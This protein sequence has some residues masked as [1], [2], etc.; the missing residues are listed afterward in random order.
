MSKAICIFQVGA[1]I[2]GFA[3]GVAIEK[4]GRRLT[5]LLLVIPFVLGWTLMVFA[6][7][8]AMMLAGR[9]ITGIAECAH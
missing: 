2:S 8:L 7:T 5:M 1:L 3:T 6:N 4:I 9:F